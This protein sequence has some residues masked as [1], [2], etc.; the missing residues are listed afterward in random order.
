MADALLVP[1]VAAA[2]T[3]KGGTVSTVK[4]PFVSL[5]R[6]TERAAPGA[7]RK[8]VGGATAGTYVEAGWAT[9]AG[10]SRTDTVTPEGEP[11]CTIPFWKN[12][13]DR[14]PA[15]YHQHAS[16]VSA[17]LADV[18]DEHCPAALYRLNRVRESWPELADALTYPFPLN[19]RRHLH[20]TGIASRTRGR[21]GDDHVNANIHRDKTVSA[22]CAGA[23]FHARAVVT[24]SACV[25]QDSSYPAHGGLLAYAML[26]DG[27]LPESVPHADLV[28][29]EGPQG[30]CGVRISTTH[31]DGIVMVFTHSKTMLHANPYPDTMRLP[32]LGSVRHLRLVFYAA[33]K[34]DNLI[35]RMARDRGSLRAVSCPHHPQQPLQLPRRHATDHPPFRQQVYASADSNL[36]SRLQP[37]IDRLHAGLDDHSVAAQSLLALRG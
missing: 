12:E 9:M 4:E 1:W 8:K 37:I 16:T 11:S 2:R 10:G 13:N 21:A 32:P 18:L 3:Q 27:P 34:I 25:V 28:I 22:A 24:S 36:R 23:R 5:L 31:P 17:L 7:G 14:L 33:Q 30:G 15:S 6:D 29:F 35:L 26:G 19:D 20:T